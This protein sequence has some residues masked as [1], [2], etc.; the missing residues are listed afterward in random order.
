[1]TAVTVQHYRG[2]RFGIRIRG[3][4]VTVDQPVPD[5][6]TDVGPTP[7]ELFVAS[8]AGC[9]AFYARRYLARH[10]LPEHGLSVSAEYTMASRP[11]RVGAV[12][13]LVQLPD[14]LPAERRAGLL[15]VATRCTVHNSLTTPP[16]IAVALETAAP[17]PGRR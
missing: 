3:H 15:A 2:D 12:R 10:G 17:Q 14:D 16:E 1:M 7:T 9:V 8:L 11:A 13:I 5:G 6:G 4:D